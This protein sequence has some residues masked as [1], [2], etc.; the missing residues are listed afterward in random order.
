VHLPLSEPG[1]IPTMKL[2][3]VA[4]RFPPDVRSGTE[5]VFESLYQR[6]RR[7]HEVRLVAG[8]WVSRDLVPEEAV[9]VDL[10]KSGKVASYASMWMSTWR[11]VLRWRPDVVLSNSI[12]VPVTPGAPT[13]C[14]VHDLNFGGSL[15]ATRSYLQE[16]FYRYKAARLSRVITVSDAM[17]RE[18]MRRG[19]PSENL[20]AIRNGVDI[21]RFVPAPAPALAQP[22][23]RRLVLAYPSRILPGKGQHIAIDAVSRLNPKEKERI[24]LLIVGTVVDPVYL[25]RL[26]VQAWHQPV[27][28]YT[29]VKDVVPY[30]QQ[31]DVILFTTVMNEG[32]GFTAVEGMAVG[33]PVIWSDQPAVR[34]AT[35]AIGLPVPP[36]DVVALRNAIRHL[37]DHPEERVRL[38]REGR[39]FV[40]GEYDW[41]RVWRRYDS[42]LDDVLE[43]S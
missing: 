38:G 2:L 16:S 29:E 26:R 41:D 35:G 34:E 36:N 37:I 40:Q 42:L 21:Q 7:V 23:D 15:T 43:E 28:F 22:G 5:T 18:L 11:E 9:A 32:F 39:A 14:I 20:V 12:E 24:K 4:R 8:Y 27:E 13:I 17:K 25:D 30:Y 33:K 1:Y 10:R 19:F 31:A 3:M 6:A